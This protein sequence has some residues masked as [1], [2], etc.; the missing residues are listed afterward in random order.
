MAASRARGQLGFMV[1]CERPAHCGL[2]DERRFAIARSRVPCQVS[3]L[4]AAVHLDHLAVDVGAGLGDQQARRGGDLDRRAHAAER[5]PGA[6]S[7]RGPA[8]EAFFSSASGAIGPGEMALVVMFF[9]PNSMASALVRPHTPCL[10]TDTGV[11]PA[12]PWMA[13]MPVKLTM[14][15]QP[16]SSMPGRQARD[17][18]TAASRSTDDDASPLGLA[19]LEERLVGAQR[20]IVDQHVDR[21]ELLDR[22]VGDALAVLGLADVAHDDQRLGAELLRLPWRP[23]SQAARSLEPLM[24]DVEAVLGQAEHAGAADVAAARR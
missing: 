13:F 9:G 23:C 24:D 17:S 12:W 22:L 14:R 7:A 19:H 16:F 15:P 18:H 20:C 11:R 1:A 21:A 2:R 8:R 4:R 3:S 5:H 10:A 6:P